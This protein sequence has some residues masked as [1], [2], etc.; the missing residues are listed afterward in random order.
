MIAISYGITDLG[1]VLSAPTFQLAV[2]YNQTTGSTS[3]TIGLLFVI[4]FPILCALIR[5]YITAGR[6]L[7]TLARYDATPFPS[8]LGKVSP[9][10]KNPFNATITCGI[11]STIIGAIYVASDKAFNALIGSFVVF[12]TLSYLTAILPF[13]FTSRFRKSHSPGGSAQISGPFQVSHTVGMAVNVISC[14]YIVVFIV[15]FCFPTALPVELANM[16]WTCLVTGGL[17]LFGPRALPV[18]GA[19]HEAAIVNGDGMV[20]A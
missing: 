7:W 9:T 14:L 18:E 17:T 19:V 4:F 1:A 2:I 10:F 6:T 16:N 8:F 20:K 15:V 5:S 13:I 11:L 12:S 3:A